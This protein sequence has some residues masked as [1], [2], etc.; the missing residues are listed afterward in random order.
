MMEREKEREGEKEEKKNKERKERK[1]KREK[2]GNG[3]KKSIIICFNHDPDVRKT[4]R[5]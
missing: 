4:S 1:N 5:Q 2:R 3:M